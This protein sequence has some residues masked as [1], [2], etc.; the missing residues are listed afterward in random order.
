MKKRFI[1]KTKKPDGGLIISK[2]LF[3]SLG[4]RHQRKV[5]QGKSVV[6]QPARRG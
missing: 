4:E 2:R 3:A 1:K 5:F 6:A